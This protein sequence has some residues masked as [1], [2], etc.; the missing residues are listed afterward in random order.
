MKNKKKGEGLYGSKIGKLNKKR[1]C[2][3][4][5]PPVLNTDC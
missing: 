4:C 1:L 2:D 5:K 3:S